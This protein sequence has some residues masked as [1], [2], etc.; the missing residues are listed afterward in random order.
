MPLR[1]KFMRAEKLVLIVGEGEITMDEF[2]TCIRLVDTQGAH[3]YRK[4]LDMRR[5]SNRLDGEIVG[6]LAS[7][8]RSREA[9]GA[10]GALAVVVGDNASLRAVAEQVAAGA[11]PDR[12]FRVFGEFEDARAWM[13]QQT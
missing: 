13:E 2:V 9:L 1:P 7:L 10:G 6:G 8:V 11:P 3:Q 12:P 4:L 5:V